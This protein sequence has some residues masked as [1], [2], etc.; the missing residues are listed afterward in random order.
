MYEAVP[1]FFSAEVK[2]PFVKGWEKKVFIIFITVLM[3]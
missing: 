1:V 3:I 2:S